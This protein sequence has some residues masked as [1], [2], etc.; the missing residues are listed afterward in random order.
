MIKKPFLTHHLLNVLNSYE[1]QRA[2]LDTFLHLYFRANKALGSK[3]RAFIADTA[4]A[5]MRQKG[6]I[7]GQLTTSPSWEARWTF[8]QK[9]GFGSVEKLPLHQAVS[10]PEWLFD[11]LTGQYGTDR[12]V[13]LCQRLNEL[14]PTTLRVNPEKSSVK[15]LIELLADYGATPCPDTPFGILLKKRFPCMTLPEFQK[16]YFELQ[17]SG[18]QQIAELIK[19]GPKDQV[20]DFCAGSGGK[21]L[22]FAYKLQGKGQLYL[23]DVRSRPLAEAKRRLKRADISNYQIFSTLPPQT[24]HKK[25]DWIL[26]DAP[27]SGIG[28]LRR[29][30]DMK[31]RLQ[32]EAIDQLVTLQREIFAQALAY[33]APGGTIV[34]ATCS[35]LK[36][37][38]QD[39]V[40][41]F[42]ST[43][44]L[45]PT[46]PPL[47]TWP[48]SGGPDGFFAQPLQL[49]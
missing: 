15:A 31:W 35:L 44:K 38:N 16:G 12:A 6:R 14:A 29:N 2:P 32:P 36:E 13:E 4:Y 8:Y 18:S 40:G 11:R 43:H 41:F 30:P 19:A 9:Q 17:D 46:H 42:Q 25:M 1:E 45:Q 49:N 39:Q 20:M 34:Y 24:L 33:L 48:S 26:V 10:F 37:E 3:D 7:D 28:T 5:L 23:H 47:I 21:S 22:A 27:C